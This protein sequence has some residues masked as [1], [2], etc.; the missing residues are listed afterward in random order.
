MSSQRDDL[1]FLTIAEASELVRSRKLSP[2]ELTRA[3]LDRIAAVDG[4]LH[5][6]VTVLHDEAMADA[7]RAEDEIANGRYRGRLH[8][9]PIAFKDLYATKGVRTTAHSRVL[10][11]WIPNE[12]ATAVTRLKDAGAVVLGKLAMSEFALGRPAPDP[13]FPAAR[14]PWDLARIPGGSSSGSGVATAAGLCMGSLGSDTGGSIRGPASFCGIVGMKPT[15]GRVSRAGVVPLGWTLDHCGPMTRTVEDA[16]IML[17]ALAGWDPR[18]PTTSSEPV[19]TYSARLNGGL[20]G[21]VIG[22][23]RHFFF[24]DESDVDPDVSAAVTAA[25]AVLVGLGARLVDITVPSLEYSRIANTVI[26]YGE[27]YAYHEE[28]L[29]KR[30]QDYGPVRDQF[31]MG[32]L[33]TMAD[34]VQAQRL[35]AKLVEE[36]AASLRQVD[37]IA[38]PSFPFAA[39]TFDPYDAAAVGR[40]FRYLGPF[41]L[42]G[43]PAMSVPCGFTKTELPIGLQLVAAPFAEATVFNAGHVYQ[44]ATN[45]HGRRPPL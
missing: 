5:S 30:P 40:G 9:I 17:E 29:R 32:G 34:Y 1:C 36:F 4:A 12:D 28:N 15:Y 38:T 20:V 23:P 43:L 33:T 7:R 2:T 26:M 27:A 21:R 37:L 6:Y 13:L 35:R 41:N 45:F 22:V 14:N 10:A 44:G 24:A 3:Y 8:G 19:P 39:P 11:D 42:T 16:A 31:L 25:L 18:D